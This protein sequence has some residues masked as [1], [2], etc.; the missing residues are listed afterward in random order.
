MCYGVVVGV[1]TR[2]GVS[3]NN[4]IGVGVS[5]DV[6][7]GAGVSVIKTGVVSLESEFSM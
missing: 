4:S 3:V 6:S 1:S 2:S 5:V 7:V